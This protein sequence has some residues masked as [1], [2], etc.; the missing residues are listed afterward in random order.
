MSK[1]I[2]AKKESKPKVKTPKFKLISY[3]MK[4]IIPTGMYANL[5]PEITVQA[6]TIEHA[7]RAV[8]PYIEALFAKYREGGVPIVTSQPVK[9]VTAYQSDATNTAPNLMKK[10]PII[11]NKKPETKIEIVQAPPAIILTVPH[12]RAKTAILSCTSV[13]ALKLVADQIE[14]SVKLIGAEKMEL[15]KLVEVKLSE[16]NGSKKTT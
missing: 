11:N 3:T 4:A 1:K 7:E 2:V 13:E 10:E 16:L 5:Q 6:E 8:M 15:K 14:K 12:T 9:P